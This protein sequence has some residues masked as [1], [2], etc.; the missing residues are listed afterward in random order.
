MRRTSLDVSCGKPEVFVLQNPCYK[1]TT[2]DFYILWYFM[3]QVI[4]FTFKVKKMGRQNALIILTCDYI[5][6]SLLPNK[7]I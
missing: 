2:F 5:H 1:A 4:V 6:L 7:Y 3:G